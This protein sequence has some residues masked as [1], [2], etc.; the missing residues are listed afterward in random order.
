AMVASGMWWR[1][2]AACDHFCCEGDGDREMDAGGRAGEDADDSWRRISLFASCRNQRAMSTMVVF[3]RGSPPQIRRSR[4]PSAFCDRVSPGL[5]ADGRTKST[6]TTV[7]VAAAPPCG[8][9]E[10]GD[11]YDYGAL[12]EANFSPPR[13][14]RHTACSC[15]EICRNRYFHGRCRNRQSVEHCCHLTSAPPQLARLT[16]TSFRRAR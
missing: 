7:N 12:T 4:A 1:R 8:S 6:L 3:C 2:D 16:R 11:C 9:A 14:S 13:T 5:A 10:H 15:S